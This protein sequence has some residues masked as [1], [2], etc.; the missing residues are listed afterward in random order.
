MISLFKTK[1]DKKYYRA[2]KDMAHYRSW[3]LHT[4]ATMRAHGLHNLLNRHYVP[5]HDA[6][7]QN[8]YR[9]QAFMFAVLI[10]ILLT[11]EGK[12]LIQEHK[13]DGDARRVLQRLYSVTCTSTYATITAERLR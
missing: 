5:T 11:I 12:Q 10:S 6:E 3:E 9:Q 13:R 7:W 8:F 1:A 2:L 4:I